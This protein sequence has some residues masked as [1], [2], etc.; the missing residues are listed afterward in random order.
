MLSGT[1]FLPSAPSLLTGLC[2]FD[3]ASNSITLV[4]NATGSSGVVF[5]EFNSDATRMLG[6]SFG[7]GQIDVW[8]VS[9]ADGTMSLMKQIVSNDTLGPNKARQDSPHPHQALL[10]NSGRFFV[11][12]DLGTD[13]ILVRD[14]PSCFF[15]LLDLC[16]SQGSLS[17][18]TLR[19]SSTLP[20]MNPYD[21]FFC[22]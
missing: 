14:P 5:L 1:T 22:S 15:T 21:S 9:A 18:R 16:Q 17:R 19:L 11:V 8:D 10:D 2:Q 3:P 20:P 7:E 13:T 4:Q 6:A 12:N